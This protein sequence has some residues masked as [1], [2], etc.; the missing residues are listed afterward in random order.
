MQLE[1]IYRLVAIFKPMIIG[2]DYGGGFD[3][4]KKLINKY[5]MQ[6][7]CKYQYAGG[8]GG[9]KRVKVLFDTK[10]G[11]YL[12]S[13]TEVMSDMFNAIREKVIRFPR[14]EDWQEPFGMDMLSI[15]SEYNETLRMI[16]YDKSINGTDDAFHS[17]LYCFFCSMIMYPR[18]DI[19]RPTYQSGS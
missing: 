18:P 6:R 4:N 14:W 16:Q 9:G 3:R 10:R 15:Y 2:T 7:V 5:G 12:L 1:D 8:H 17:S 19:L 13:R 11:V